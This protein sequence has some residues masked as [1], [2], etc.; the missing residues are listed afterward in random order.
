MLLL[1]FWALPSVAV[2]AAS[3]DGDDGIARPFS[4]SPALEV[5]RGPGGTLRAEDVLSGRRDADFVRADTA[6]GALKCAQG[7]ACWVRFSLARDA[8]ASDDW[9]LRVRAVRPGSV[10]LY[11]PKE[12]GAYEQS[13]TG[14]QFPLNWRFAT[15]ELFF[16]VQ[17]HASPATYYLRLDD[18]P[19]ADGFSL[20]QPNGFER[21]QRQFGT[22]LNISMGVA[23]ALLMVNLVF[24][25]WL[26]DTLFL[27]FAF[28][29]C[30]AVLLHAWQTI[31]ATWEPQRLGDLALRGALQAL[32]QA[33]IVLFVARLFELKRH[34]PGAWRTAQVFA[35]LNLLI[36]A[37]AGAGYH[38]A[39]EPWVATI[40][41]VGLG[42][43][44]LVAGWLLFVQR[45]WQFAWPAVLTLFLAFSSGLGRL[46]WLGWTEVGPDEGLGVTWAAVRLAYMLLLAI[47]VADRTRQA[48]LQLRATRTRALDDALRAERQLE[49]KVRERT[50]ELGH[51]NAQLAAE[52]EGRRLAEASLQRALAS[53]REAMQQQR[54]FVSLVSHEFRTPLAVI[55]ATAQSIALPG[56]EIQPRLAKIRRAVQRLT[57]LVVNCL[58]DDRFHA[59]GASL[60]VARVDLRALVERLVL[61]FG[62]TDRAR[63]HFS[64]PACEAWT[65][66]DAALLEIALHNLVQNAVHYSPAEC[67]VRV[68]LALAD[69]GMARVDVEDF[70]DGIPP[71]EQARIFERFFRGTSSR[72]ASG[73]GL[74][75][76]LCSE[77]ARAHGGHAVLLR[78]GPQGSVFRVEVPMSGARTA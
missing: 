58:A 6:A 62:P 19:S 50:R 43:S 29:M 51:S 49:D 47:V 26:R 56:V 35:A 55:D 32:M 75:L 54:Q 9:L 41:L 57:L 13:L 40:D 73:T 22:Y 78:S 70:G 69:G 31:P 1:C 53:E 24:W 8:Q 3:V 17:L 38:E 68:S 18:T 11:E 60:K 4:L 20:L 7:I 48:E 65:D 28:V 59:E 45:Q 52:I 15:T 34:L 21:Q 23:F 5:L 71:D 16:P 66:G 44:V 25:R 42:G 10:V 46:Q 72:K 37:A 36:G 33:A 2:H 14:R 67:D 74:G 12:A 39:L 64:L 61:A 30:A 76:F 77:I 27:H 63:I